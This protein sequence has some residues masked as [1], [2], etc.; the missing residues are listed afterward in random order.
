MLFSLLH[1]VSPSWTV[2]DLPIFASDTGQ[3]IVCKLLCTFVF[4]FRLGRTV[5]EMKTKHTHF[6][7]CLHSLENKNVKRNGRV[8]ILAPTLQDV[9]L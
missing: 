7:C 9:H 1:V 2:R 5:L 6:D 3:S 8:W 4:G